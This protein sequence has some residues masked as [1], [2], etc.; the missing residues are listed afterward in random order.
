[1]LNDVTL[2]FYLQ[3]LNQHSILILK[4]EYVWNISILDNDGIIDSEASGN[5]SLAD[6]Y[7]NIIFSGQIFQEE[8][9]Y[10][11]SM[12]LMSLM[13][14]TTLTLKIYATNNDLE[15]EGDEETSEE[16]RTITITLEDSFKYVVQQIENLKE[17]I[18]ENNPYCF[19][20]FLI[21]ILT[22]TQ[23]KLQ[24]AYTQVIQDNV[25]CGLY[26]L[27]TALCYIKMVESIIL[28][29][30][31]MYYCHDSVLEYIIMT[32]NDIRNNVVLLKGISVDYK[33]DN[34]LGYHI[35]SIEVKILNL[36]D[37]IGENINYYD[38]KCLLGVLKKVANLLETTLFYMTQDLDYTCLLT[39][40]QKYLE[41]AKCKVNYLLEVEK[42]TQTLADTLLGEI[43]EIQ[44]D[45]G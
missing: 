35:A 36:M 14:P 27:K 38:S 28:C 19:K 10:S 41:L 2:E 8:S 9:I 24:C 17:F 4:N 20:H 7:G 45:I 42:I 23:Q 5:F 1:M 16:T 44:N 37:F 30:S 22:C 11:F 34:D 12:D 43:S 15:W 3:N 26:Y 31:R 40:A 13:K 6:Q 39:S 32:L 25:L 18:K 29:S 21:K 33:Q